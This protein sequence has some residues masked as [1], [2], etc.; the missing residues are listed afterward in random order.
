[1][2]LYYKNRSVT[3]V[4][5]CPLQVQKDLEGI[6]VYARI[7][8]VLEQQPT[9]L[10]EVVELAWDFVTLPNPIVLCEPEKFTEQTH[11]GSLATGILLIQV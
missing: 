11:V 8:P 9:L 4:N 2:S 6:K 1:M 5:L 7:H 10:R 3:L